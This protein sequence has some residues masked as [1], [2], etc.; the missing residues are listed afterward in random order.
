VNFLSVIL[1]ALT[2]TIPLPEHSCGALATASV[3]FTKESPFNVVLLHVY[4]AA[5]Q[6][7]QGNAASDWTGNQLPVRAA[8][9]LLADA[10]F[11]VVTIRPGGS[12]QWT[13]AV[14]TIE[15]AKPNLRCLLSEDRSRIELHWFDPCHC[16]HPQRLIGSYWVDCKT[17]L[18]NSGTGF[19]RL[20]Q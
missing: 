9:F 11:A 20:A 4:D 12:I 2:Q 16:W 3:E 17:N 19:F 1:L 10:S 13:N 14:L 18:P 8:T 15:P 5:G 6:P 7:T